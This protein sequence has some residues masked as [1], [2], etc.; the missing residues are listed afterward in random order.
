MR[1]TSSRNNAMRRKK[2]ARS[3]S[4]SV[5]PKSKAVH[6]GQTS[7]RELRSKINV[8][9]VKSRRTK[10]PKRSREAISKIK[11]SLTARSHN[12]RAQELKKTQLKTPKAP[13]LSPLRSAAVKQYESAV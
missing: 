11:R 9:N 5:P 7:V 1:K 4:K 6:K 10:T 13:P 8:R 12:S 3:L 2:M